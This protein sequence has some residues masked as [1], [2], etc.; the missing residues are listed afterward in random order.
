MNVN[1]SAARIGFAGTPELAAQILQAV[2]A[3][4]HAVTT[5]YTQPDRPAG[6]GRKLSASP[7]KQLAVANGIEVRQP[8]TLRDATEQARFA[9]ASLDLLIVAAYGLLLPPAILTAPRQGCVNVHAS[10]LPRWRGAAPIQ[11]AIGAGDSHTGITLMQMD[12]G[13]DTGA[14]LRHA[15][16]EIAP[17]E[18]SATLHDKLAALGAATLVDA[19][20]ELLAGS[21]TAQAQDETHA[22]YAR[23]LSKSEAELDWRRPAAELECLVRAF[24]P[25]PVAFTTVDKDRNPAAAGNRDAN[26]RLR[27]WRS[28]VDAATRDVIPGPG[29]V[30]A[31]EP[32]SLSIATGDGVLELLEVQLPGGKRLGIRDFLNARPLAAGTRFLSPGNDE[33]QLGTGR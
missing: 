30:L 13:L 27:I 16:C 4:N 9:A 10:L 33:Q 25:W 32:G 5:V 22:T 29:T 19:L 24:N 11:R 26:Q 20:P 28:Q 1:P 21:L 17:D 31:G 7:V 15:R 3:A 18:T 23:R 12:E 14:M 6:R 2:L 8:S